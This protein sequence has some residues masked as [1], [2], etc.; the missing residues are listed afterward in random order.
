MQPSDDIS[1]FVEPTHMGKAGGE[2]AIRLRGARIF[3]GRE[4]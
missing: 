2:V 3:L 4:D 1:C